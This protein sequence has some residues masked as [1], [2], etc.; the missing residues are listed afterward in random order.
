MAHDCSWSRCFGWSLNLS[1]EQVGEVGL[2][3]AYSFRDFDHDATFFQ[4]HLIPLLQVIAASPVKVAEE[5]SRNI[6]DHDTLVEGV[7][8][9]KAI[10]PSLLLAT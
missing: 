4:G 5:I 1:L 3:G 10:L 7:V 8:S 2:D 6:V 9:K